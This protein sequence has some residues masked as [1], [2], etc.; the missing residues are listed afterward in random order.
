MKNIYP[1]SQAQLY[2][3]AEAAWNA[4][5]LHVGDFTAF[6]PKYSVSFYEQRLAEIKAAAQS[7]DKKTLLKTATL[8]KKELLAA[9]K[10]LLLCYKALKEYVK[11]ALPDEEQALFIKAND[12]RK[13][14]NN[15]YKECLNICNYLSHTVAKH[16][17]ALI[18]AQAMP[19][20]F[21]EESN[22]VVERFNKSKTDFESAKH[23]VGVY[24]ALKVSEGNKMY[25]HLTTMLRHAQIIYSNQP[26]LQQLF[27]FDRMLKNQKKK[28]MV[29]AVVHI[30]QEKKPVTFLSRMAGLF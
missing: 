20:E 5:I 3:I 27:C 28:N 9:K 21:V 15:D 1:C 4:H 11:E 18:A 14:L 8:K 29:T 30:A 12:Y 24:T 23:N 22:A 16:A 7:P 13:A 6:Q 10:A 26:H 25:R 19:A 17:P 2:L